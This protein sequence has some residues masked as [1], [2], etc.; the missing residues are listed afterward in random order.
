MARGLADAGVASLRFDLRGH[1]RS[2]GRQEKLTISGVL[3]DIR[4]ALADGGQRGDEYQPD[5]AKLRWRDLWLLRR[6]TSGGGRSARD[7]LPAD[8]LQ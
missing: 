1:G 8:G 4:A 2:E 7:A 6:R 3:N 5:R